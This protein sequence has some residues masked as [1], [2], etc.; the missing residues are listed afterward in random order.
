MNK[1]QTLEAA[2]RM[3]GLEMPLLLAWASNDKIFPIEYAERFAA[4]MPN[5]RIVQIPN[6]RTFVPI[7]QPQRL[8]K[9]IAA[10]I[11]AN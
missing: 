6:A 5:A 4:E 7:D 11:D 3:R 8:A 9:E 1:R 2:E 10:F